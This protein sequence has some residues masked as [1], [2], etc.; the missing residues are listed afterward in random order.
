MK[1]PSVTLPFTLDVHRWALYR[2]MWGMTKP[3]DCPARD[4]H[5]LVGHRCICGFIRVS[6][7]RV[8]W[9]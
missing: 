6:A 5:A 3:D 2:L 4:R 9:L 7:R 1:P 8:R